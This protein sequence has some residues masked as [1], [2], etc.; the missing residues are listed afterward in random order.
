[1]TTSAAQ[2]KPIVDTIQSFLLS[3][4]K[5][6]A[7]SVIPA[8][9]NAHHD[10][11]VLNYY[12]YLRRATDMQKDPSGIISYELFM[13]P[14]VAMTVMEFDIE[15]KDIDVK[16]T[17]LDE[18]AFTVTFRNENAAQSF[19]AG[20]NHEKL[21]FESKSPI[22]LT[23][24]TKKDNYE[25]IL[26]SKKSDCAII[27]NIRLKSWCLQTETGRTFMAT[28]GQQRPE[29]EIPVYDRAL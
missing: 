7:T 28:L 15:Y 19:V 27:L 10:E 26:A 20:F 23:E 12:Q 29:L 13:Q 22:G 2:N 21:V 6:D 24:F 16:V 8:G 1:M 3:H 11:R 18:D 9:D 17:P 25:G 4:G 5:I 14:S